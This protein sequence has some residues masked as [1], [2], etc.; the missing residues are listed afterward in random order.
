MFYLQY[1][2]Q[3]ILPCEQRFFFLVWLLAFAKSFAWRVS[4]VQVVATRIINDFANAKSQARKKLNLCT[5]GKK[6]PECAQIKQPSSQHSLII[7]ET[8]KKKS[9]LVS[10][11][12]DIYLICLNGRSRPSSTSYLFWRHCQIQ[13][14]LLSSINMSSSLIQI[15]ISRS[16]T[17]YQVNRRDQ[18][19][20]LLVVNFSLYPHKNQFHTIFIHK[21]YY[22]QF[23]QFPCTRICQTESEVC[24][25]Q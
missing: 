22:E 25:S 14:K 13:G 21:N 3:R 9:S 10:L 5:Q 17:S 23:L 19:F 8:E 7:K 15:K 18:L 4:R 11:I 6:I 16:Q 12:F 20:S 1:Q 2:P 24:R